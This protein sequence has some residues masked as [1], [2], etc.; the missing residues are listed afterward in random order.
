MAKK[1]PKLTITFPTEQDR[2]DFLGWLSDGGGE[3]QF[4]EGDTNIKYFDYSGSYPAWGYDP[5]KD[6]DPTVDLEDF[7]PTGA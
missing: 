4:M 1:R 3:Y 5:E 7:F 2:D 6:G